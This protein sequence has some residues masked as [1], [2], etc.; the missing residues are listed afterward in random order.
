MEKF[1]IVEESRF[2]TNKEMA[3][4][5]GAFGCSP[6]KSCISDDNYVTCQEYGSGLCT[7]MLTSCVNYIEKIDDSIIV[8]NSGNG[9]FIRTA[10]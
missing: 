5:L 3:N 1:R 8:C 7:N 9:Y 10:I 6:Y 4:V 2:L